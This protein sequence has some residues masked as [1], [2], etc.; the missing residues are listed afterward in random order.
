LPIEESYKESKNV[1][2]DQKLTLV[3]SHDGKKERMKFSTPA[4]AQEMQEYITKCANKEPEDV[5]DNLT[6]EKEQEAIHRES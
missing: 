4:L 2:I 6:L 3:L 5:L 1:R